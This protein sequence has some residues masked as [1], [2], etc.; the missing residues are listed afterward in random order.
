VPWS[1]RVTLPPGLTGGD[2]ALPLV[3]VTLGSSGDAGALP[4]VLA[5]LDGLPLRGVLST[6]GRRAPNRVPDNFRVAEYVPGDVLASRAAFVITNGGSGT[7]YQA[8][9]AGAPVLGVPSNL[10][11]YLAM[12]AITQAGAGLMLRSGGLT[13]AQVRTAALRL[14]DAPGVKARAEALARCFAAR[15]CHEN[16]QNWLSEIL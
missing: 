16:F 14:L 8:L 2:P 9:A 4:I 10:D 12:H 15:D 3:Y 5:G 1:P 7:G 11:Q 6:A 13:P